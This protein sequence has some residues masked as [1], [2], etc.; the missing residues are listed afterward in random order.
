MGLPNIGIMGKLNIMKDE[1]TLT[2]ISE[3]KW[4]RTHY[5]LS[6]DHTVYST[7]HKNNILITKC[8][9]GCMTIK[10]IHSC[11][12][13][14]CREFLQQLLTNLNWSPELYSPMFLLITCIMRWEQYTK[15]CGIA[16]ILK[17]RNKIKTIMLKRGTEN[18][19]MKS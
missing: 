18:N 16:N 2:G 15:L 6:E 17:D 7:G 12:E 8:E 14:V 13:I 1:M 9:F 3:L 10:W 19:R 4:S 11:L 5:F